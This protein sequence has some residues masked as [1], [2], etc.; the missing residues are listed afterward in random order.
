MKENWHLKP[1]GEVVE[2]RRGLTY[3][4][5]DEVTDGGT[6]VLRATNVNLESGKLDLNEIRYIRA[7]IKVPVSKKLQRGSL[8]ICTASGSK[9]HLGKT[10]LID[11]EMDFAFGG[12][13]GLLV[14]RPEILPEYL[15]WLTRA[16]SYWSFIEDLSDGTNINNLKFKD[17]SIFPTPLPPLEEQKR[18]VAVLDEAFEGLDRTRAN[19][20]ANLA[21]A[22]E[23]FNGVL[24]SAME[25]SPYEWEVHS[26]A[27]ENV[28]QIIDGDRGANYPTKSDFMPSGH[29]LFLSTKNVRPNGFS[30]DETMF[31]S[32]ERD[33]LLRKGKIRRRDVVLTT[34]GTIGNV[35][36]YDEEVPF[37]NIRINSGML[38]L[39][40]NEDL[41]RSEFLFELL[42]SGVI[43]EQ[44]NQHVS[45]AAQP[46]LPIRSLVKFRLPAP[47][48]IS[49]Q[50]AIV[51]RIKFVSEETEALAKDYRDKIDSIDSL[52]QSLLQ[53]AFSG[54][55]T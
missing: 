24:S 37:D 30:F 44:I 38:I 43:K 3:G 27:D 10:C 35:A 34:R 25:Q 46:Q 50:L 16:D 6:A 32:K 52:R 54:E 18:I 42:R 22:R 45:G 28:L 9:K 55:L 4:K 51:E 29:C 47:K 41:L 33:A 39:R 26:F 13:M 21:D 23:L 1:L 36:I 12:F 17:L 40:P 19:A 31:I 20:E 2:F 5:S 49:D 48:H 14:P 7:D 8:L 53:K 11:Q 15:Y